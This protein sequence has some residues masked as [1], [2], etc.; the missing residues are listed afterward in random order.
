MR[1]EVQSRSHTELIL[2]RR[3][4]RSSGVPGGPR[5]VLAIFQEEV[6]RLMEGA[7]RHRTGRGCPASA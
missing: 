3:L 6:K 1:S 2:G 7:N 5:R 4:R